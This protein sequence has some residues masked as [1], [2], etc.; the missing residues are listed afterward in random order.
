MPPTHVPLVSFVIPVRNGATHLG[1]CLQSIRANAYPAS[2]LEI[3]VI[4]NGSTDESN[5]VARAFGARVVAQAS[6]AHVAALRNHG[7]AIARGQVL[8]FVDSDHEISPGWIRSAVDTLRRGSVV[9]V[10]APYHAPATGTWVQRKYDALRE[11]RAGCVETEWLASGNM[12]V[13]RST[14]D[15]LGGFDTSLQT[16]EDVDFSRRARAAGCGLMSDERLKSVH[17]GDPPTLRAVFLS[18]LWRGRDG[19][20]ASLRGPLSLRAL[21]SAVIPVLNLAALACAAAG[22]LSA[23]AAGLRLAAASLA[24]VAVF[25]SIHAARMAA[26][27]APASLLDV[28]QT[29]IVSCVYNV[30]RALAPVVRVDHGVRRASAGTRS[31]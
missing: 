4:D 14:F 21:P 16:C 22:L 13:W 2:Y 27:C 17:L 12:A 5:S 19:L 31:R 10:G 3:V 15:E 25:V 11:R 26:R 28:A 30:A 9:G 29:W 20:R 7:A 8:A 24:V 18:E 23:S 1:A 6:H